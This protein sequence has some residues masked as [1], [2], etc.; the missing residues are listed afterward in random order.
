MTNIT[1]VFTIILQ[2]KCLLNRLITGDDIQKAA[3][4][5]ILIAVTLFIPLTHKQMMICIN[6]SYGTKSKTEFRII[7]F[8]KIIKLPHLQKC[9]AANLT[10]RQLFNKYFFVIFCF[11]ILLEVEDTTLAS[12]RYLFA[13]HHFQPTEKNKHLSKIH[14]R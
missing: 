4:R 8:F 11:E 5:F 3:G 10:A 9:I 2:L 6:H 14:Y 12:L 1:V 7:Y 13:P